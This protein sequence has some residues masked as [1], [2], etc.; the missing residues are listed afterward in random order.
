MD[1]QTTPNPL[2]GIAIV[3]MAGRF[4]GAK[5]IDQFWQNLCEGVESISFFT[6]EEL[7]AA[8]AD[9]ALLNDA[10]YVKAGAVLDDIERFDAR[11]FGFSAREAEMMDPQHRL[12]LECA[13]EA[14]EDAG[15]DPETESGLVGVY[16]GGNLSSYLL[17]NLT[18]T[19]EP[20]KSMVGETVLIGNDKDYIATR[21]SY[22]LN[23]QG[24]SFNVS[25]AC[26]TS[27]VAV[28]L[29]CR[30]LL[31]YECDAA[32]A[33]GIAIQVPQESGYLYQ[34]G[35]FSSPD[36][37]CRAFDAD[38][39]GTIFGNGVGIVVLKRLE[40]A[41]ADGDCIH[42]V[43]KG[44]AINNDGSSKVG[45]TA[46]SV[47]GQ[48]E[49]IAESQA[50]A[51]FNPETITYIEAHGTG[52]ALGDPI[53][54]AALT[55]V[56]RA[57][58][59][60]KGFCGIGSVKTNVGHLNSASGVTGL[61]KTVLALKHQQIPPSLHFEAPNPEIDFANSPFYVNT[62]LTPWETNGTPRRAGVSSFG[63]GGTNAHVV[64]EEAPS[65]E[66]SG[67]SRPWQ[68]LL[69][70]AK[71]S[72]ALEAAT[73]NLAQYL[74]GELNLADVAYTLSVGRRAFNHRR[75]VVSQGIET[76]QSALSSLEPGRVGTHLQAP[77]ER[78][79]VF[80]FSGQ[81]AQYVNMAQELYQSEAT[82]TE[83][84]DICCEL[85][86]PH[87]GLDLRQILYPAAEQF[88]SASE[89]LRQTAIAQ[90]ALF[91]I[92]YA[93]A[94]LWQEW[95]VRPQAMMGH[96][97]GEYVAATL[98]SVLSLEDAL[99]LVAARG[100]LMQR[101]PSGSMLAVPLAEQEVIPLLGKELS[102][103]VINGPAACVVSGV[104]GAVEVL[105]RQLASQGIEGRRLHTSHA[106]HSPM[107]E[108]I[109]ESFTQKVKQVRLSAP[110]IPYLSNVT[111]TWIRAE[112]A[113]SPA[114]W[115]KHLRQPVQWASGLEALLQEPSQIL[116][117]IGPGRTLTTLAKRH[118]EK[119]PEQVVLSCI[120][121]PQEADSDVAF[122]LKTVGQSW[123]AGVD[124][125]W[126]GFYAHQRRHRLPL[127]T[128]PFERQR[129]WIEAPKAAVSGQL[130]STSNLWRSL[131]Q[132]GQYQ[133]DVGTSDFDAEGY[134]E[135]Q[136]SLESLCLA[137]MNRGLRQLG[138]FESPAQQDSMEALLAQCRIVPHYRQLVSRWLQVLVEQGQLKQEGSLFSHLASCST[139]SVKVL[140]EE[141]RGKWVDR[142]KIVDLVQNCGEN[143]A[144]VLTGEQEP[145]KFFQDFI[146]D[147]DETEDINQQFPLNAYYNGI[148]QAI[149]KQVVDTL[150]SLTHLRI[151]E[152]GGGQGLAT[153]EVLP[154]L[155][156]HRIHYTFTD[157][158]A[159][160]LNSGKKRFSAYPFIDYRLLDIE[161][162]PTEQGYE[163]H[164]FD[165][166]IAVNVLHATQNIG[167]T[168]QH[169]RSLLAPNGLLLICELTQASPY[170]DTT[171]GLLM[172]PV[173][174]G[175]RS[176]GNPFLSRQQWRAALLEH[177]FAE[178]SAFPATDTLGQHVLM[179]RAP[180]AALPVSAA[181]TQTLEPQAVEKVTQVSSG[182]KPDMTDW[183]YVPS[184]KRSALPPTIQRTESGCWLMF[185][186]ECGL[187]A[188]ILQQL[189]LEG[190]DVITVR[191]GEQFKS[192]DPSATSPREYT[193]NPQCR[194]DYDALLQDL[195]TLN[196]TPTKIVHLWN[197]TPPSHTSLELDAIELAQ[198]KGLYSLLFL[199]QALG[200]QTL[201]S[202]LQ[203]DVISSH[204]QSV[205]GE[206]TL[207]IEKAPL[208]GAIR[209]IPLEYPNLSCRSIDVLLPDTGN[210]Q[211]EK[212]AERLC[213]ELKVNAAEPV[214]AYRGVHRW[215][216]SFEPVPLENPIEATPRLREAGVYLITGGLGAIGLT[217]A[218]YLAKAVRAKLILVGRS[219]FPAKDAWEQWLSNHGPDTDISRKILQLQALEALGAEVLVVSADVAN[220]EQMRQVVVQAQA[221]FGPINGVIHSAGVLGDSM[222][223]RKTCEA[224]ESALSPKVRGTLVLEAVL[225]DVELDFMVLCSSLASIKPLFGQ[226]SYSSANN[227]LDAFAHYRNSINGG[228]TVSINWDGW[229][230]GGMGVEGVKR[231]EQALALPKLQRKAL[232]HPLFEECLVEGQA[233]AIYVS[234]LKV[235]QHWVLDEHRLMDQ[236]TLPGTAYLE[237]VRAAG[238]DYTQQTL[239]E[240]REIYFLK[241]LT[242]EES[243]EK[244]VRTILQ[245]RGDVV[246]FVVMSQSPSES[247]GWVEHARGKI[248][249]LESEQSEPVAIDE[250]EAQCNQQTISFCEQQL[251]LPSDVLKLG[252]RWNNLQW[253]KQG[254][255][256][257]LALLEL[258]EAY[259]NDL[260]LYPLHPALLDIATAFFN[261]RFP[262]EISVYLPFCYKR[263]Q[264]RGEL[265][266]RIYSYIQVLEGSEVS[267]ETLKFNITIFNEAGRKLV[268]IEEYTLRR[269][270]P[271]KVDKGKAD[272]D[273]ADQS[274][275]QQLSVQS[276]NC[277]LNISRPGRLHTLR[278]QPTERQRPGPG[279]VEIEVAATGLNFMEVLVALGLLPIP[280]DMAFSFGLECAGR[281]S[282]LGEGV[283][284]FEV[285]DEV[286]ALGTSCFS[287]FMTTSSQLVAPKPDHLSLEEA[288]TIPIAF[289]TA[290]I[291]LIHFGRLQ[292]GEKVL[293][294]SAAG[295]VG[296]AA[297]QIAQWVGADIFATAGTPEKR[298]F[299]HS[300]GIEHVMDSHSLTFADEVMN[301]TGGA[302]V[303][304]V[305]NSLGG[306]FI[307]KSLSVLGR[308]GRFLELG[309]RDIVN[310]T[311]LGLGVFE[312]RLSFFAVHAEPE[313]PGFS[314]FWQEVVKHF[315]QQ[316]F[317]TMPHKVFPIG[318]VSSAFEY[319]SQG[320]HIGK[321]VLSFEDKAALEQVLMAQAEE[322]E[323][324]AAL[325][326]FAIPFSTVSS[327]VSSEGRARQQTNPLPVDIRAGWLSPSEGVDVFERIMAGSHFAQVLVSTSD[328]L[329]RGEPNSPYE[330]LSL[331]RV[332]NVLQPIQATHARPE[333]ENDYVAPN[334]EIEQVIAQIWQEVLG[335]NQIGIHDN[336]FDLGGDSLLATQVVSKLEKFPINLPSHLLEKA[337]VEIFNY[338]T[339]H[340][341]ARYLSQEHTPE[342]PV[343]QGGE[344]AKSRNARQVVR[345]K[346]KQSR[347]QHRL[348]NKLS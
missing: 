119:V 158:G 324:P 85:L 242:V 159:A 256:Q 245:D 201:T 336:F 185:I 295:G 10:S 74:D 95:G 193:V 233:H 227:F 88:A 79:V 202:D 56:F 138:V 259:A 239:L 176:Q 255:H 237:M 164:S 298:A 281:V 184:W 207:S 76:A 35:G 168:L 277:T 148:L 82:F 114:Y 125:D 87:L 83:Q 80:M 136:A 331:K 141:V 311:P 345:E 271:G 21:A 211:A 294:H 309:L 205:T 275:T 166:A 210:G 225:Q 250:L 268:E 81:G 217:L 91:V 232:T 198:E 99:A 107:M 173:A 221:R 78:P 180:A 305:L 183:F 116:L 307:P 170:F 43:I 109:L 16:A 200:Q 284:G 231:L 346:Q 339:I 27:L 150:P 57:S 316:D 140:L 89:Q 313:L 263:L 224:I 213:A 39:Q 61:I 228:L 212:L 181:F 218:A 13:W 286:I 251:Q 249:S 146:Y 73:T 215:L 41:L 1:N 45:Y 254:D 280:A 265:P 312:K 101:L 279:E 117:E 64:L 65:V 343:E 129:Y 293:I 5:G 238:A 42:A 252:A 94:H 143:L 315:Q 113:T 322:T 177:G 199:V 171:W 226:I 262:E 104:T 178:V 163:E 327:G 216:Q 310:D 55:Q 274:P 342:A 103:A 97:I 22:K 122:L 92:E 18:A 139:D 334:N 276:E 192:P 260:N 348:K 302:G 165:M 77:G 248:G 4:P 278:F 167:E 304:V 156:H 209:V 31:S 132:A 160:F 23:L 266:Q 12:F 272:K 46:P 2:K 134:L 7:V 267:G 253:I 86:K 48:A 126:S 29:A 182:K 229:Q 289:V 282:A 58:T 338:S 191:A 208:L 257:A 34:L 130:P 142:P 123:L 187:G 261:L 44:S 100:K 290:Y 243:E 68:L 135:N 330:M 121:H 190:H 186:D 96:S 270:N 222:I 285:G 131:V 329:T 147:F 28:H 15:Y 75:F 195:I 11:F 203:I 235:D 204:L 98:A 269:V 299:L 240:I 172:N 127:P 151:L 292:Q 246:E 145:L 49:A 128:Y 214:I 291:A 152:V 93:L 51:G 14:L 37:H 62:Q 102:I 63:V 301:L 306:E 247:K 38:A 333:L 335:I 197:V 53:E 196:L 300:L 137:Y 84:V 71:T 303:D 323:E 162:P 133:A 288:A 157:I 341:F 326:A 144:S 36:G 154:V 241:P 175:G 220:Y 149:S 332:E 320:K 8:G 3:G 188:K 317:R 110:Q 244:E 30:G 344:R 50:I 174:D 328:F 20:L 258:S 72:S 60:K 297:V 25:T 230:A 26:S 40:D 223:A 52:T 115:A 161:Q 118:P 319:M 283:E 337:V 236:A 105:E 155:P 308:Y 169:I 219:A 194:E 70:S 206:E 347:Q 111:G 340:S 24:P 153:R 9:S 112:E 59:Q 106:F 189:E 179:A 234:K 19:H 6:D 264:V 273:S 124:I 321:I 17:N 32:L 314:T 120:R 90:P 33:G 67:P 66:A 325:G 54:I 296:M 69:L 318:E 47:E 108:P 287:R